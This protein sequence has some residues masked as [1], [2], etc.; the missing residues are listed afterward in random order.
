MPTNRAVSCCKSPKFGEHAKDCVLGQAVELLRGWTKERHKEAQE[1]C[2]EW[3]E[4]DKLRPST[5]ARMAG[6]LA[7]RKALK[8][9]KD[10]DKEYHHLTPTDLIERIERVVGTE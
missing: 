8:S 2:A 3:V 7:L 10:H 9:L 5:T 4:A 6:L 1:L